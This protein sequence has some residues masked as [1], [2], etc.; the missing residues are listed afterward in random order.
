M[1]SA[2]ARDA[3]SLLPAQPGV[4]RFRDANGRVMY[5]GRATSLRSRVRSYWGD[6]GERQHLNRMV[7]EI[8]RVEAL[9]CA[10]VHEAAWLERN[11]L[12]RS[13]PRWNRAIGGAEVPV[14]F[15][16]RSDAE[17]PGLHLDHGQKLPSAGL[18][19][20]PYLGADRA[21]RARSGLLRV[22]PL[23]LTG[24]ADSALAEAK[25]VNWRDRQTF[26][27]NL[28]AVLGGDA[29]LAATAVSALVALRNHASDRQAYEV[30]QQIQLEIEALQWLVAPQRVTGAG[31]DGHLYGFFGETLVT[32]TIHQG[33]ID[34]W[35]SGTSSVLEGVRRANATP[36][37]WARFL[38]E[39][40][41]LADALAQAQRSTRAG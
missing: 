5:I 4:Y 26:A 35:N 30:A 17:R 39:N 1:N 32:L 21:R 20:G 2:R 29:D 41:R 28:G 23:Q 34:H 31:P 10:S 40:A 22:W 12:E 25:S 27:D 38:Y 37:V 9:I 16:L 14:W 7:R 36:E 18:R 3:A 6:L 15:Q 24:D 11:L 8:D 33:R 13:K 19:F